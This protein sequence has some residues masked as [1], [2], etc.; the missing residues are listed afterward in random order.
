MPES[1]ISQ[2]KRP[3]RRMNSAYRR[4]EIIN[5]A[6]SCIEEAGHLSLST[7]ELAHMV[8][9]SQPAIFRH[10]RSKQ[11]LHDAILDE[12]NNRVIERLKA[13]IGQ[14]EQWNS[15][16]TLARNVMSEMASDFREKPGVW[17]A[18][19]FSR[20]L[21]DQ[22]SL[23]EHKKCAS[24]QLRFTLER[25]CQKAVE[26]GELEASTKPGLLSEILVSLLFG[27]GQEWLNNERQSDLPT[28]LCYAVDS[29][30]NGNR[31]SQIVHHEPLAAIRA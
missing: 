24:S 12:A 17:L 5:A 20:N 31:T 14:A 30:L 3:V 22:D 8:G 9:I 16:I 6:F 21:R 15:P 13:L 28:Q 10:F 23:V 29:I 18:L 11:Q 2:S 27:L 26:S 1:G 4:Q 19:I 7:T 25:I